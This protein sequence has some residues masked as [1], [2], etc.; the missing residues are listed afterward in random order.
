MRGGLWLSGCA[1]IEGV[2]AGQDG[3]VPHQQLKGF[4]REHVRRGRTGYQCMMVSLTG[5]VS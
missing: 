4:T 2:H 3:L 1:G 5:S